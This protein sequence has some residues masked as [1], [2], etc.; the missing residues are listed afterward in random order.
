MKSIIR[1]LMAILPISLLCISCSEDEPFSTVSPDDNP[2]ILSPLFPDRVN[3]ELP[4]VSN[5]NRDANF[6]MEVTVTPADYTEVVW[7]IDGNEA[8][9]GDS[10]DIALPAGVYQMKVVAT[11]VKGKS[12]SREGLVQVNPLAGDPWAT[13]SSFER[14]VAPGAKAV[15]YGDNLELVKGLKIGGVA[16][17][18][19]EYSTEGGTPH[20]SYTVPAGAAEGKQRV[21]LIDE[22]GN[23]YGA[24]TVTVSSLPL[25]TSGAER[26]T[27]NAAWTM[28][29]INL[30]KIAS[31]KIGDIVV[32]DFT[33]KT[34]GA[35]ELT[36]PDLPDGE[37]VMTGTMADGTSVTFY[38][39]NEIVEQVT[40]TVSSEQTLWSG[41]HYVSWD[42]PDGDPNK[43]FGLGKD[44][45]ASIKAGAVLSIHYSIEPGDVYHQ[46][47][48]TTGWWTA[49]PGV[50]K[51]DVSADGVMDI[52]LTQEILDMIQA[53]DGFL[54]TGHGYYVDL[55][56]LK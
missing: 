48:P 7:Y 15:L 29:G 31:L 37:Y 36:C 43:T 21:L 13:T 3:G 40:V 53:E 17:D 5:I 22:G 23:E 16:A 1:L 27:A 41:H 14:F 11:T 46:I 24:N 30:D 32:T 33:G 47:Q 52:T 26:T 25:V 19:V 55:V 49:F 10:I 9:K 20:I 28:T 42:L 44:V 6:K 38:A 56:T 34:P 2:I 51:E 4:V 18:D 35:I 45:F 50:D 39:G 12:T 54:C 8:A